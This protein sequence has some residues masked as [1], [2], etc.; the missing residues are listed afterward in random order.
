MHGRITGLALSPCHRY[1]YINVRPWPSNYLIVA[2]SQP[3]PMG[4]STNCHVLDLNRMSF[5]GGRVHKQESF[6]PAGDPSC[7]NF[8]RP[9][10]TKHLIGKQIHT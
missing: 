10:V 8:L 4:A 1:L 7:V 6:L 2:A 5:V 9:S 3:P